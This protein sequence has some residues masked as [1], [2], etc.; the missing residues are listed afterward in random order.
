MK[1]HIIVGLALGSLVVFQPI[2]NRLIFEHKGLGFTV[3][4]NANVLFILSSI[5]GALV[6]YFPDKFPAV[7]RLE[8]DGNFALWHLLPGFFGFLLVTLVPLMIK[9]LGASSTVIVMLSG[10]LITGFLWDSLVIGHAFNFMRFFG[11]ILAFL[12]A[13]LSFRH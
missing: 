12:G 13:Y 7:M 9:N 2:L 4:Q 11:I 1:W 10:Q 6:I 3:W 5:F 8:K